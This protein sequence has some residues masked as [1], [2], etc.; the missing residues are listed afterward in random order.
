MKRSKQTMKKALASLMSLLMVLT[1]FG[2]PVFATTEPNHTHGVD[3][4]DDSAWTGTA[5]ELVAKNY[6]ELTDA[7]K[8]ILS[9]AA[10]KGDSYVV[11]VPTDKTEGLVSVDADAKSVTAYAYEINGF[12]W[13]PTAAVLKYT[14]ADGNP[15]VDLE[16]KLTQN[17]DKYV[18]V[19]QNRTK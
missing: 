1:M 15:G 4:Q 18:G 17:G 5:G 11:E 3:P 7:E 2:M 14:D 19:F 9:S 6:D 8:A 10:M 12:V 16:V 13:K